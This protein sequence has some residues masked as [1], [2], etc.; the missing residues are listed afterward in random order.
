MFVDV[1]IWPKTALFYRRNSIELYWNVKVR[2][3]WSVNYKLRLNSK[4]SCFSF[5]SFNLLNNLPSPHELL[6]FF[7][8]Q[9][10]IDENFQ[11]NIN[12]WH[13][14]HCDVDWVKQR[15]TC[16]KSWRDKIN[17][18]IISILTSIFFIISVEI[19]GTI[20]FTRY[21]ST[22]VVTLLAL[23]FILRYM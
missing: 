5:F 20:K 14:F 22:D 7:R 6:L 9:K 12:Q 19:I 4:L 17:K 16:F 10:P 18:M 3:H 2:C 23:G 11:K 21:F 8:T 15:Y 13:I 1:S